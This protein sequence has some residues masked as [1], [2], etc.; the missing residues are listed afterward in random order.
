MTE[1]QELVGYIN[2]FVWGPVMLTFLVGTGVLLTL[3]L[4]GIQLH[5]LPMGL[6]L[7]F[8]GRKA[9]GAE[10]DISSFQALTTAMAATIGT[11][12]IAGVAT[13]LYLGGPGAIFWMWV[14]AVFG[15]ATKYAEAV[16]AVHFRQHLP[17]G[18]MQGGPMRYLS[19]GLGLP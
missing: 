13:A 1:L 6:R 15:M 2:G 7:V 19:E 11:G 4:R 8:S 9:S 14:C 18:T 5:R 17:D 12:N 10:G 16:L 3:R